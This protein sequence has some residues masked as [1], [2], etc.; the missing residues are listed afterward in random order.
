M[1]GDWL[2]VESRGSANLQ[3]VRLAAALSPLSNVALTAEDLHQQAQVFKFLATRHVGYMA[4]CR[5]VFQYT[6]HACNPMC[7]DAGNI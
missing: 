3:S 6:M 4:V 2:L 7:A 5:E 1:G